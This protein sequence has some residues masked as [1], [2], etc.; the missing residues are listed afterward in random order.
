MESWNEFSAILFFQ[1]LANKSGARYSEAKNQQTPDCLENL[2]WTDMNF[3]LYEER[4]YNSLAEGNWSQV[5]INSDM[6]KKFGEE[7]NNELARVLKQYG[8]D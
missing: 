2:R 5:E 4:F 7:Y 1:L 8:W 6:V 3:Y